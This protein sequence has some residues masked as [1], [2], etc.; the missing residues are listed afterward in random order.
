MREGGGWR[1]SRRASELEWALKEG[2][3]EAGEKVDL[4][5]ESSIETEGVANSLYIPYAVCRI[6]EREEASTSAHPLFPSSPSFG[7]FPSLT[8][9][10]QAMPYELT[11]QQ[12]QQVRPPSPLL[13]PATLA[14]PAPLSS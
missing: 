13:P 10:L 12:K 9:L 11:D 2:E 4:P 7:S 6:A 14:P 3:K 5:T 8:S 1:G